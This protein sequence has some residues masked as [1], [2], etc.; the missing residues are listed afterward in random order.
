MRAPVWLLDL[1][2]VINAASMTFPMHAWPRDSWRQI[3]AEDSEGVSW[4]IRTA[5]P[6]VDFI[7]AVHE[8]G[9]AEIR[10]HTTWQQDALVVGRHLG[11]PD[12]AVAHAPEYGKL[13][14][15]LDRNRWWKFPAARRVLADEHRALLWTDDDAGSDLRR[16]ERAELASLGRLLIVCPNAK[17]GLRRRHL[18]QID[19][20]LPPA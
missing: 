12:F 6:V 8:S 1:D 7:R 2:G 20:F 16:E 10:W 3:T 4:P 5:Q 14:E 19:A 13:D 9:R 15:F 17:T 11:L 18:R